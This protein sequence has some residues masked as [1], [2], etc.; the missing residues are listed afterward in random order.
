MHATLWPATW[1]YFLSHRF[2]GP[3][4]PALAPDDLERG[5]RAFIDQVRADGPLPS[6]RIGDQPYGFLPTTSLDS[7]VTGGETLGAGV[8]DLLRRARPV[9][10]AAAAALP[11]AESGPDALLEVLRNTETATGISARPLIGP[12]Y[13]ANLLGYLGMP[14][15]AG[16]VAQRDQL[17]TAGLRAHR[18]RVDPGGGSLGCSPRMP[19]RCVSRS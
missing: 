1:G 19:I 2:G 17:G 12:L 18:S 13:A 5:R 8:V 15:W 3:S 10:L 4:G 14:E 11:R 9:W 7:W 16:W 6:L